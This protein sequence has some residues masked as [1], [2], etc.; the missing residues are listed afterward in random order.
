MPATM[1]H[2]H[3]QMKGQTLAVLGYGSIGQAAAKLAKGL[4]MKIIAVRRRPNEVLNDD[5]VADETYGSDTISDV[6]A[7]SDYVCLAAALTPGNAK[8]IVTI[9]QCD[10]YFV[11]EGIQYFTL[12]TCECINAGIVLSLHQL[13]VL[14]EYT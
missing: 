12:S 13:L 8:Y 14:A 3:I 4:G 7:K 11:C 10:Y 1:Q 6:V 5:G 9:S 2:A